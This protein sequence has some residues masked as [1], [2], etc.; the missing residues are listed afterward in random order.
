MLE[1]TISQIRVQKRVPPF[2]CLVLWWEAGLP[3]IRSR[4][5]EQLVQK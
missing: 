2:R 3:H 5:Q 4:L 1:E